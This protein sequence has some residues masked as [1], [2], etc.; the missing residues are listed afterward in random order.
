MLEVDADGDGE[1]EGTVVGEVD[2]VGE[3]APEV[4]AVHQ[5]VSVKAGRDPCEYAINFKNYGTVLGVLFSKPMTQEGADVPSGYRLENGNR[6]VSVQI[7]PGGRVALVNMEQ[8]VSALRPRQMAVSGVR[9]ARGNPLVEVWRPVQTTNRFGVAIQGRVIRADGSPVAGVPVTLTYYDKVPTID[10]CVPMVRRPTQVM[11]G[12]DGGFSLDFVLAEVP[13]AIAATDT[14]G[15]SAEAM[16]LV[17]EAVSE[18]ALNRAKLEALANDPA[19]ANTLLQQFAVGAIPEAIARAEG[20]DRAVVRDRVEGGTV[21]LGTTV[22]VALRF[23]G[24]G[25]VEGRVLAGDGVTPVARAAVN[26]VPDPESRELARGMFTDSAGRFR[27]SGVPLGVCTLNAADERGNYRVI[28]EVLDE[29]NGVRVVE[30]VLAAPTAARAALRGR[31]WEP[32]NVT[33][34]GGARVFVGQFTPEGRMEGVVALAE[35]EGSGLWEALNVPAAT[36]DVLAVSQDGRRSARVENVAASP[37]TTTQVVLTLN[38][39]A[40]VLGK[41]ETSTGAPVANALVAGGETL[42]RTDANGLF[43]MPG[44]P[45]GRRQLS[46]GVERTLDPGDPKSTPAFDFPRLGSGT[47]EV[48]AGV[49]N[50]VVI[51][52]EA[53]G[54]IVGRVLD[55][56]GQPVPG[57]RVAIPQE[58][59]FLYVTAD[60]EGRY[61]F[62][63]MGLGGYTLS[64]PGP[65]VATRDVS[66]LLS[67]IRTGTEE[68]ILAAFQ[69]ALEIFTGVNDPFLNGEGANFNP[70][71]WGFTTARIDF[72][73][74]TANADI[75]FLRE[76]T[77]RGVVVNAQGVPIGAQVRLTGL[78]PLANG[79]PSTV[80]RGEMTSDPALGTF[81]FPGA[82]LAGPWGLQVA[83]PFY[84]TVLTTSGQT[85]QVDPDATGIVMQFP[86]VREVN[87]SLAGRVFQPDGVPA[88]AD[89]RVKISFGEDYVIR[90][91]ADGFYRTQI[92]LP[93]GAYQV[94]AEDVATGFR[95]MASVTILPGVTNRCDVRLLG[96]GSL[97]VVV[98]QANGQTVAGAAVVVE[99]AG[100]PGGRFEGPTDGAGRATFGGLFEGGYGVS[101]SAVLGAATVSG[102]SGA[103]VARGGVAAVGVTLAPTATL[104]GTFL[105]RDL[106]TPV[107]FAQVAVGALGFATTDEQGGFRIAGL[108][109]GTYR[110]ASQ[111]PVTGVGAVATVTLSSEGEERRVQLVEQARGEIQGTV[112]SS[113]G[114]GVVTGATVVLQVQDGLTPARS[115]TTGPDGRYR[116]PGTPAGPFYVE[117]TDP[118]SG[119]K[120][121][122]SAVLAEDLAMLIVDLPLQPLGTL[123][124]LVVRPDGA[125]PAANAAVTLWAGVN[126]V[127]AA[128][129]D[130][131]GRVEFLDLPL[132]DYVARAGSIALAETRSVGVGNLALG[133][134]GAR[135]EGVIRLAGVGQVNGRAVRSDGVTSAA[136]AEV[137]L[138]I[139]A[140]LFSGVEVSAVADG[141]GAF[142]FGNVPVGAYRVTVVAE[143]LAGT[144]GGEITADGEVDTV[145]VRLGD[146][147]TVR[148][149]M[150]RADGVTPAAGADVVLFYTPQSGLPGRASFR[151]L[152]GGHFEFANIPVGTVRLESTAF[153]FS[154][155][156]RVTAGLGANGEVL[157]VGD[158]IYDEADPRVVAVT[159]SAGA[160]E[161]PTGVEVELWFNEALDPA[162]VSGQGVYVR[163]SLGNVAADLVL[164]NDEVGV[165]RRVRLTPLAPLRSQEVY[166]VVVVDGDRRNALGAVVARGPVDLVGRPL[167]APFISRFTTADNDPPTVVSIFPTN[168]AVQI[169][170]RAVPR[171]SLNEPVGIAGVAMRLLG[172]SGE[173]PGAVTTGLGGLVLN[174]TPAALLQPNATY[175]LTLSNVADL[176]GNR[177]V[178]EPW[179][180]SFATLDTVG[181]EMAVLRLAEGRAPVA[182]SRV[183]VEAVLAV[184]EPGAS[185][186]FTQDFQPVG[187]DAEAPF[188]VEVRLP[189]SGSTT[190]RAIATD[191][192]N[193]DGPVAELV[194]HVVANEPPTVRLVR[195]SPASGPVGNGETFTMEA[196]ASD[197]VAV[198]NLSVVVVGGEPWATNYAGGD[199]QT[200]AFTVPAWV[201]PGGGYQVRAQAFDAL[202]LAS[203]EAVVEI[204]VVDRAAPVLGL[205]AP[206][207]Q[208]MLDPLGSLELMVVSSDNGTNGHRLEVRVGEPLN[209]VEGVDVG[210]GPGVRVTNRWTFGL[211]GVPTNGTPLRVEARAVDGNANEVT[212]VYAFRLPDWT[213]PRL[214][215][216]VPTNEASGV[217]LWSGQVLFQFSEELAAESVS[218]NRI[219]FTNDAGLAVGY[220]V[221]ST[222]DP[223]WWRVRVLDVP[224]APG[225]TWTNLVLP[226]LVDG[227][228]N[229]LVDAEG[230]PFPVEGRAFVFTTAR[231]TSELPVAGT[232]VVPGQKV[233]ARAVFESGLG[234]EAIRFELNGGGAVDVP[235]GVLARSAEAELLLGVAESEARVR[236][237][238]RRAGAASYVLP[239]VV[240][241]VAP[242]DGD[243]DGDSLPNGYEADR[244]LDPFLA[245]SGED[246]DADGLSNLQEYVAGTDPWEAD[247]DGDG[248]MDGVDPAPLV[249]NHRPVAEA[250]D[251]VTN[252]RQVTLT[253]V[254]RDEDGDRLT[255]RV[256]RLPVQGRLYQTSDGLTPGVEVTEVPAVVTSL[257]GQVIY[258]AN[259]GFVGDDAVAF[260]VSDGW[261]DSAVAGFAVRVRPVSNELR[262]PTVTA[263]GSI[264]LVENVLG[265]VGIEGRDA[266]L[267][268]RRLEV[269]PVAE[270][271]GVGEAVV[272]FYALGYSLG[273][274]AQVD[275]ER[276]PTHATNLTVLNYSDSGGPFW[277]GGPT[278]QFAV[279]ARG[280]LSVPED[281]AYT[282]TIGS[283]D[284]SAL[285]LDGAQVANNDGLHGYSEVSV[286]VPLQAGAYPFETRMFEN[287]GGA[288][289]AVYW[290]GPSFSRR[291]MAGADFTPWQ[292]LRW[293]ASGTGVLEAA[294]DT[295]LLAGQLQLRSALVRTTAVDVVAVDADNLSVTQRVDVVV[296]ADLDRDGV[297]DRDD[298]DVDGDGLTNEEEGLLGTDPR[299]ADTDGDGFRDGADPFP[300]VMNQ[301]PVLAAGGVEAVSGTVAFWPVTWQASDPDGPV[302]NVWMT[303][304][305]TGGRLYQ[306]LEGAGL[307]EA[308]TNVPT[309]VTHPGG[310]VL[311]VPPRGVT[312]NVTL[313]ARA[314]DGM[315]DSP[316]SVWTFEV[317][318]DPSADTDGDGMRDVI[319]AAYGLDPERPDAA[320]DPDGDGLTNAD[321]LLAGTHPRLADTDGDGVEDGVELGTGLNPLVADTDGDGLSDGSDPQPREVVLGLGLS[322]SASEVVVVEGAVTNVAVTVESATAPIALLTTSGPDPV[323]FFV[324]MSAAEVTNAVAGGTARAVVAIAPL[325]EAAGVYTVEVRAVAKDGRSALVPIRIEVLENPGLAVT[326]WK[327]P[328][329]GNWD[330]PAR[331]TGGVPTAGGVAVVG[332]PG[333]YT[334]TMNVSPAFRGL[335]VENTNAVVAVEAQATWSGAVEWRAGTLRLGGDRTL[336]CDRNVAFGGYC[337]MPSRDRGSALRGVGT[338]ETRGVVEAY[339]VSAGCGGTCGALA[340]VGLPMTVV[341]GGV[342]R[343]LANAHLDVTAGGRLVV[344]GGTVAVPAGGLLYLDNAAP[345]RDLTVWAG[346]R[347]VGTGRLQVNGSNRMEVADDVL[348]E[349][350]LDPRESS[351]VTGAGWVRLRGGQVFAGANVEAP[352]RVEA[353]ASLAIEGTVRLGGPVVVS[354][355]G[356]FAVGWD[357]TLVLDGEL[358]NEGTLT[359]PSRDRAG[360]VQGLGRVRNEGLI[361]VYQVNSGCGGTCGAT[362][363]FLVPVEVGAGGRLW[364]EP[365]AQV[366]FREGGELAVSGVLEV[367]SGGVLWYENEGPA[368]EL[369]LEAGSAVVGGG[370]VRFY[371][372]NRM[373]VNAAVPFAPALEMRDTSRVVG[374]GPL[375]VRGGQTLIGT[376][377]APVALGDGATVSVS[378][379]TFTTELLIPETALLVVNWDQ[380]IRVDGVLTNRGEV[381]LHSRDKGNAVLGAGRWENEGT[382]EVAQVNSGCG[383]TCGAVADFFVPVVVRPGAL[384]RLNANAYARFRAGG[385][386]WVEGTL[387]VGAGGSLWFENEGSPRDLTL[388]VGSVVEGSGVVRLFGANRL[389]M[390]GDVSFSA[391]LELRDTSRVT[392]GGRLTF[393][394]GQTLTGVYDAP[395]TVAAGASVAVNGAVFTSELV[396]PEGSVLALNWDQSLTVHGV[397]TNRGTLLAH[398]RDKGN[399]VLGAGRVENGGTIRVV[400]VNSGCGGGCGAYADWHLPVTV[401]SG[402]RWVVE[403]NAWTRFREGGSLTVEGTLEV[404]AGGV[405][406]FENEGPARELTLRANS[407]V[408]GSGVVRL[409]G[410]NRLQ[411]AGDAAWEAGIELADSSRVVGA[412]RLTLWGGPKTLTGAYDAPVTLGAGTVAASSGAVFT[413]ELLVAETASLAVNWDQT[414]TI[415]GVLTNRGTVQM[416]SRDRN[417]YLQGTGRMENEGV[418]RVGQVNAGCGGGCGG[419]AHVSLPVVQAVIGRWLVDEN[420]WTLFRG[421]SGFT[422]AGT[423]EVRSGGL[424]SFANEAPPATVV[425]LAGAAAE[426]VGA[427]EMATPV[428]VEGEADWGGWFV[429]M[430]PG[431]SMTGSAG[432]GN[433]PGG[434]IQVTTSL[435]VPGDLTIGGVLDVNAGVTLTVP[436]TLRLL[437][438]GTI[439]NQ[440]TIVPGTFVNEGGIVN[441]GPLGLRGPVSIAIEELRLPSAP[442]EGTVRALRGP[443]GGGM[444]GFVLR[445]RGPAGRSFEVESS[446]DVR[447]WGKRVADVRELGAGLYEARLPGSLGV[448]EYFRVRM[449]D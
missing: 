206:A 312:T 188:G 389:V 145:E 22:P 393:G 209:V 367:G 257:A 258:V 380:S 272:E 444:E 417:T 421:G 221:E 437:A 37:G 401:Q 227:A 54:R 133:A 103:T 435:T 95:G 208:S 318:A 81:E 234:A 316:E 196:S 382:V 98:R 86:P 423:L 243:A 47:V 392:S 414:L 154:G 60:D 67:K 6:A 162:S 341:P 190:V 170:P 135:L 304:L 255:Y 38:G 51:R 311:W 115:V 429:T 271:A 436:G 299:V 178:G 35:A 113:Y 17:M 77:V 263:P 147:G 184:A 302:T 34:H 30:M 323:P 124:W 88:G 260:V 416:S 19:H 89:V 281:G 110:L 192:Y 212:A 146:S 415:H 202:G 63:G 328:V 12:S 85:T 69:E 244:G 434:R 314:S 84:P 262:S 189:A 445:W 254:G 332:V 137:R 448:R 123:E 118:V 3:L 116:F 210:A 173:V 163:S 297:P 213:P 224:L 433:R 375:V 259:E 41:V 418:V 20:L 78:G 102:R 446:V 92:A 198:T 285:Y 410:A 252:Q 99:R 114:T 191:R 161:V 274:L 399:A 157:D 336:T 18:E 391:G 431:V 309:R 361:R 97:E 273:A 5:D 264:E 269:R 365:N 438:G 261:L 276:A 176:A 226:G 230:L 330:D 344:A 158:V 32:D 337:T 406:R 325:H 107:A 387:E 126:L 363:A 36:Y 166:D 231:F 235:V 249:P 342:V 310:M 409:V 169:D 117:A 73:G 100:F 322:V 384:L 279:R 282:F 87:G 203:A 105:K 10:D 93:M 11:T 141:S 356:T 186:R 193:N 8:G 43:T 165:P 383:G 397:L 121:S 1:M 25:T 284:G 408:V 300:L 219:V 317:S 125:S 45:T 293:A 68:E 111:D 139:E 214:L 130:E 70:A 96:L 104:V 149:R 402:G 152:V 155:L 171:V 201:A 315:L 270:G 46:A 368:R 136:G 4:V 381:R 248:T 294:G 185:V 256:T 324:T 76:G 329:S 197:D 404:G 352:V 347:F 200:L 411:M 268:L 33:P 283:D 354:S 360:T 23:R 422:N 55:V 132:G 407:A 443:S 156:A 199:L 177:L 74:Q 442:G 288:V 50:Y 129:A 183:P 291:L 289:L 419:W 15:L 370:L 187:V 159:P 180:A 167:V 331:W 349:P 143:G 301:P 62:E 374:A 425:F 369:V 2:I 441:G 91:D 353:G 440:G 277:P 348:M 335:V 49:D 290:A 142:S 296:L 138:Q 64:A 181:P 109:L 394:G 229:G 424:M 44:V 358:I 321:E 240:L 319:E 164:L 447:S 241:S 405:V 72:D 53:V 346:S 242:R 108:P 153:E 265:E 233:R 379:A 326:A 236:M 94:E 376:Y 286:T 251:L 148:G 250:G 29:V 66:G 160:T 119:L 428:V 385:T 305:P 247:T 377:E 432:V 357:R 24:R 207:E 120:G 373:V 122:R 134:A 57:E 313:R 232:P 308:I 343:S 58:N 333:S 9:D 220:A 223:L 306:T 75:R 303:G 59:G 48:V 39:R 56:L 83:S 131:Q 61:A 26:L 112:I 403:G 204:E 16:A 205:L 430:K 195:T 65:A 21:R 412:G 327:E 390:E 246:R 71:T 362:T 439:N 266:D 372:P 378:G 253:L 90:T 338:W 267:N 427:V 364:V 174:F 388:A 280:W 150:V 13:Y 140:P 218:S 355:G 350:L 371:G 298:G 168:G 238:A 101:A 334:V 179:T 228:G 144:V 42:V 28:S 278:D 128:N 292:V 366:R 245:D 426:G 398:S 400:Q 216:V 40:T 194:I 217:S 307:G 80:I 449:A 211:S 295:G 215:G 239:E 151:T 52:L 345:A 172:P 339:Q 351:R 7:Q 225:V 395:V 27:F 31:V 82:L 14:G 106:V 237:E 420:A 222:A 182:G 175:T 79:A 275:F 386:L 340:V 413:G 359:S 396:V 287:G 127:R 320:E